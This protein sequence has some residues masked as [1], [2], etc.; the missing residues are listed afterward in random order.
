MVLVS[1]VEAKNLKKGM[2]FNPDPYIKMIILPGKACSS[3]NHHHKEIR[4]NTCSSTTN[5]NWSEEVINIY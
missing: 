3:A 5:P 4:T 2:F 1:D